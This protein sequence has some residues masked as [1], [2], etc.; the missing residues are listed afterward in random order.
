[1]RSTWSGTPG[2]RPRCRMRQSWRMMPDHGVPCSLSLSLSNQ[3]CASTRLALRSLALASTPG[4]R[5]Q[6]ALTL[7]GRSRG[8]LTSKVHAVVDANGLPVRLGLT[9]GQAHDNR[10]CPVLLPG[11]RPRTWC[12]RIVAT[13]PT[14]SER[15]STSRVPGPTYPQASTTAARSCSV[16]SREN[17]TAQLPTK[18]PATVVLT[19]GSTSP[20]C[21]G[22]HTAV[23]VLSQV[24]NRRIFRY[25][26]FFL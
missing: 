7:L 18:K 14:G 22:S 3:S 2:R 5:Q 1:M 20:A 17:R 19:A 16:K 4:R 8:G 9:A 11:L 26:I 10:L 13:M 25:R 15:S 23:M 21:S 24:Y 12:W 6:Q